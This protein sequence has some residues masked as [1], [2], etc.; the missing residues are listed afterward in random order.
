MRIYLRRGMTSD[1]TPWSSKHLTGKQLDVYIRTRTIA[2]EKRLFL[3]TASKGKSRKKERGRERDNFSAEH[4]HYA[5]IQVLN[6]C[7]L[8]R[9]ATA[10]VSCTLADRARLTRK[11]ITP[12]IPPRTIYLRTIYL[13]RRLDVTACCSRNRQQLVAPRVPEREAKP[14]RDSLTRSAECNRVLHGFVPSG[15]CRRKGLQVR[16]YRTS[17]GNTLVHAPLAH[18]SFICHHRCQTLPCPV[19]D[20][21]LGHCQ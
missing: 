21:Q 4:R 13:C 20:G 3:Q 7:N 16:G 1:W 15:P 5:T 2:R 10:R 11:E 19:D 9:A 17:G 8:F 6:A 18:P 14:S 12:A